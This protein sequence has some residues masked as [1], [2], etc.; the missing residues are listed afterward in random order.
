LI[1]LDYE[2]PIMPESSE[3]ALLLAIE[4]REDLFGS[5]EDMLTSEN[6]LKVLMHWEEGLTQQEI[7]DRTDIGRAT[8][9]RALS[10]LEEL[11]LIE[12]TGDGERMALPVLTHP[13]MHHLYEKY[14]NNGG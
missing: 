13:V 12:E 8:V 5:L 7:A 6:Y 4:T 1:Y 3:E 2:S 14:R 9:S 10:E 11:N